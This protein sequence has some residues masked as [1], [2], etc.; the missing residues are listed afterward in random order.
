MEYMFLIAP[1]AAV[2]S[3]I[4]VAAMVIYINR[5]DDGDVS[6]KEIA[7]AVKEGAKAYIKKQ[8]SIVAI[9][10]GVVFIILLSLVFFKLLPIPV[11]FAFLTGGFFSAMSGFIGLIVATNSSSKT[12]NAAKT[13]LNGAL[14]IAF[15]S[16]MVMGLVVVGLA[17]LDLSIWY[18]ILNSVYRHLPMEEKLSIITST[19]L[20]FGMGASFQALFAR[21]GGGIFT[22]AADVGADIVGKVE[23][24]IPEDDPR[25]PAVIAD[26]VGDNVG[27]VAGMGADL[28]ESYTDSIVATMALAMAAGLSIKGVILPLAIAGAGVLASIVG[29]FFVKSKEGANQKNL[30]WALRRG[31][32][33]ASIIVLILTYFIVRFL[34]PQHITIY[35]SVVIG[36]IAGVLIGF[37]TEY[38]TSD[39][40]KPTKMVSKSAQTG[41]ATVIIEGIATGMISTAPIVITI[42]IAII[43]SFWVAG[44]FSDF[45][46]GLY[47]ISVAAVGML[48]TLGITLASDAYGPVADNAGG[49]AQMSK[50]KAI[51]RERTDAL[52]SL[53]NTTAATGKGF[54]IGS[55]ALTALALLVAYKNEAMMK[56]VSIDMSLTNPRLIVGIFIGAMMVLWFSSLIMKAIGRAASKIVQDVRIQFKEFKLLDGKNKPDYARTVKICTTSAQKEMILP[57]LSAILGPIVIGI[58]LGVDGVLGLLAGAITTGF[59]MAIF[60]SNAGGSW[61]NAKKF[62]EAGNFGGKGSDTHKAA[63]VGDTVGDPFKDAAGPSLNILIKLMSMVS[64]V[65]LGLTVALTIFK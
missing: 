52:D 59:G 63:V 32:Y 62:V 31:I 10:F 36:L 25:N 28:Y 34:I 4:F 16:G 17:L 24:G 15:S 35:F 57:A 20:N 43:L 51:V 46:I 41:P 13:S 45:E 54:A 27:D 40:Y 53:G 7:L 48:S 9:F 56:F 6:M 21:V 37:F 65:F 3:L 38:F 26:N 29:Y 23:A 50:Q 64:I 42:G 12:A 60:M 19:M 11:P 55:A 18:A 30:L 49:N 14:R 22:K 8:Y 44:G 47:G 2:I 5:K 61:D 39:T 33:G 1:I 58:L